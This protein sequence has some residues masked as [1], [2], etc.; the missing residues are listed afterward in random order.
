MDSS[1]FTICVKTCFLPVDRWHEQY[2]CASFGAYKHH[3][4]FN[5]DNKT[6]KNMNPPRTTQHCTSLCQYVSVFTITPHLR[7]NSQ[8]SV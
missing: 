7:L 5:S 3:L 6:T 8:L 2:F 4:I 1:T